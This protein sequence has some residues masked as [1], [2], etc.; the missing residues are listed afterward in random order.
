MFNYNSL[1][2]K[3]ILKIFAII[4]AI[5]LIIVSIS[6]L[7]RLVTREERFS[8][9]FSL[10]YPSEHCRIIT[11][12]RYTGPANVCYV[13]EVLSSDDDFIIWVDNG[14]KEQGISGEFISNENCP[15]EVGKALYYFNNS[16]KNLPE[17]FRPATSQI[18]AYRFDSRDERFEPYNYAI[19]YYPSE[20]RV[21]F[22]R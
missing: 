3:K 17:R 13:F 16:L 5:V 18:Y 12:P 7:V 4:I 9:L 20:Q 11:G 22:Y 10:P 1:K 15:E 14:F 8:Q 21:Y 6:H 19:A 2:A